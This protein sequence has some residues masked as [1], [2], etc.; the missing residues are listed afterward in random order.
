[1]E[2]EYIDD[3][4]WGQQSSSMPFWK[5]LIKFLRQKS[6]TLVLDIINCIISY[7]NIVMYIYYTYNI[8][9][10]MIYQNKLQD[11]SS[12]AE[13]VYEKVYVNKKKWYPYYMLVLH[14]YFLIDALIRIL[15]VKRP[16][17]KSLPRLLVCVFTS[18]P[19]IIVWPFRENVTHIFY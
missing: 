13:P 9:D 7:G 5:T 18:L 14:V 15:I 10:F 19:F 8:N 2:A 3:S 17:S 12:E 16:V 6:F 4:N 1:M 11:S